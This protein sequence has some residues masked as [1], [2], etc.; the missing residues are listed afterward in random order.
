[1]AGAALHGA[2]WRTAIVSGGAVGAASLLLGWILP[3]PADLTWALC[4]GIA[5]FALVAA[6]GAISRPDEGDRVTR[7][8]RRWALRHPWKFALYPGMISAALMLPVQ[9]VVDREG[10]FGAVWD[11]GWG[12]VWV[13]LLTALITRAMR[14]RAGVS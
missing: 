2:P 6:I 7:Q 3:G 8:S 14:Y 1:M 12:A 5:V 4:V 10:L 11:A 13:S 9:L